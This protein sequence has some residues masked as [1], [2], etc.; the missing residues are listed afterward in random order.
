MSI[1][2][3]GLSRTRLLI[4]AL[5]VTTLAL[6]AWML[7]PARPSSAAP[8]GEESQA[9]AIDA[10]AATRRDVPVYLEGL[11]NIQAFYTV[12]LTA[13]VD[14]ELTKVAFIEGQ[15]VKRGQLLAQIDPRPYQAALDQAIA[16]RAKD[17]AQLANARKDLAR[18]ELLAPKKLASQQTLDGQR[19]LVAQ[20]EAQLAADKAAIESAQTQLSYTRITSPIDG[21]TGIRLVDPGNIVHASDTTGIVVITQTQPIAAV[22]T[23]PE[24]ALGAVAQAMSQGPASIS[25]LPRNEGQG[26]P[27]A[28]VGPN[29]APERGTVQLID[30]QIDPTS[31]TVRLKA[32]FPNTKERLW[33][34]EFINARVLV[35]TERHALTVPSVA[36]QRGDG[37]FY[38]YVVGS[39]SRVEARPV[40]LGYNDE[41]IAIVEKGLSEGE[42]VATSNFYRLQPGAL[43]RVNEPER[44]AG[45]EALAVG[46]EP[47]AASRSS[48]GQHAAARNAT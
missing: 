32:I 16:T 33:P 34:G 40:E 3:N 26:A 5:G 8:K 28:S 13:R 46:H 38:A 9:I 7:A 29:A 41:E 35:R 45:R 15:K 42:R 48:S 22:V 18:Y 37:G 27:A 17:N 1:A 44:E 2:S 14:G 43:V 30:N 39:D 10:A 25:V 31:G 20:V 21:R 4:A 19:A 47:P 6:I 11:G 12:K 24:N 23:L 36:L